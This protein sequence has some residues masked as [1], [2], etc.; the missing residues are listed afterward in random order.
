MNVL[1]KV[2]NYTF[3][4]AEL[5]KLA[6]THR[7]FAA[8]NNERLE[9]LGDSI[10]GMVITTELFQR[11]PHASEGELS[12]MRAS[13]VNGDVLAQLAQSLGLQDH[14]QLGAGEKKTQGLRASILA[15]VMEAVIGAI[16]LDSD[17]ENCRERI[18]AWYGERVDDLSAMKPAKDAK[19]KLQEWLQAKKLPLPAY[20]VTTS[21]RSHAQVFTATCSVKGL[22]HVVNGVGPNRRAAGQAAAQHYLELLDE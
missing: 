5:L 13:L 21:G 16:Y 1:A 19:S 2:L 6:L 17:I 8:Q 18:I 10:L 11:H 20:T 15:D 9:F 22:P 12:R 4:D 14:V 7:S 3:K